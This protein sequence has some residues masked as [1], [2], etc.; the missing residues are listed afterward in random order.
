[1]ARPP[2]TQASAPCELCHTPAHVLCPS[3]DAFLCW[4]CD[5]MVHGA[6]FLVA[7]HHRTYLC[8]CC[9]RPTTMVASGAFLPSRSRL[10]ARCST[11]PTEAC[12]STGS[13]NSDSECSVL[14]S[15]SDADS[16]PACNSQLI[17]SCR[18]K[19][20]LEL[21]VPNQ[22]LHVLQDSGISDGM[23][24]VEDELSSSGDFHRLSPSHIRNGTRRSSSVH[25]RQG[26][27]SCRS[28]KS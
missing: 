10:C 24:G 16:V 23:S 8:S 14:T 20:P 25:G 18:R 2:P 17:T 15:E 1:M 11:I 26:R 12:C 5:S 6:N 27:S 19:R 22:S 4:R 3:D 13:G 9:A 28:S 7:R 21:Q